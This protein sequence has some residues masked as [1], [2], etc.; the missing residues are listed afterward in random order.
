MEWFWLRYCLG[1]TPGSLLRDHFWKGSGDYMQ[2]WAWEVGSATCKASNL[3]TCYSI[4]LGT[5]DAVY[6]LN[7]TDGW[8]CLHAGNLNYNRKHSMHSWE[9]KESVFEEIRWLHKESFQNSGKFW[10]FLRNPDS[11][12]NWKI[13]MNLARYLWS[14]SP[15]K[16]HLG[17]Q[18]PQEQPEGLY[19][20]SVGRAW[21]SQKY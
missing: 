21:Y 3:P 5:S 9:V 6:R 17:R 4:F 19:L 8:G 15:G 18:K 12:S 10:N 13:S 1:L 20:F 16:E 2:L 11:E 7:G 14:R